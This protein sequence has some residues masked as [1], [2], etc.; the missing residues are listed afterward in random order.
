MSLSN[1]NLKAAWKWSGT[2][3]PFS[4]EIGLDYTLQIVWREEKSAGEIAGQFAI[5][6]GAV[7]QLSVG[8]AAPISTRRIKKNSGLSPSTW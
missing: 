2:R 7:S 4:V 1:P 6:F 8:K 5:T 3:S